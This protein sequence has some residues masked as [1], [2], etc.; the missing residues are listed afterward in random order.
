MKKKNITQ[1]MQSMVT[2]VKST[3]QKYFI[4]VMLKFYIFSVLCMLQEWSKL[5]KLL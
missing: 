5:K 1:Q 4:F 2:K 3:A